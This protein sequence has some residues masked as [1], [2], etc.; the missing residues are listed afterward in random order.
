M[1]DSRSAT[2]PTALET[3]EPHQPAPLRVLVIE[4]NLVDARLIQIMV[5]DAGGQAFEIHR[6][7]RLSTALQRLGSEKF[8]MVL[9]DLSLPD[10][11]GLS[12]F[13][14]VHQEFPTIP[15]IVMSG[16]DDERVAVNAVHEGAQDYLVKGQVSGPLLVRAMRYAMERK[17]TSDQLAG[18]AEELRARNAQME[19]DFNMAREIQQVF[20]PQQYPTFPRAATR[21]ESA[22]QF[23]HRYIPAAAVGGDF[24]NVFPLNNTTAGV[25]I[26]DVMGHGMRAA[27]VTAILRGLVEQ[28]IPVTWDAGKLLTEVNRSLHTILRRTDQPMMSTA[29]YMVIDCAKTEFQFACAGHPS[30]LRVRR[31]Q[32]TVESLKSIDPRHGPAL[33]LFGQSIYPTCTCPIDAGDVV[34]LFTDGL[35]EANSKTGEE[36]GVDRLLGAVRQR[37]LL[38]L[39]KLFDDVLQNVREFT[40]AAEFE[41][42]VC[43]LGVEMAQACAKLR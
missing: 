30:P 42:D 23:F 8:G 15:I 41:D 35:Y 5:S 22:L 37:T 13:A 27:L 17:R 33:G 38:P 29:F 2:E 4:D 25:F 9:L 6:A 34:L 21:E 32:S 26:C 1:R 40:G 18:Y 14:R 20:L 7:D 39:P 10:S 3:P 12:T 24:F 11:H 19:A 43:L 16:L 36:Y 31:Q 28:L